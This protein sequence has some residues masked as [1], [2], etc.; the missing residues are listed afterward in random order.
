MLK[1][2]VL[3]L[4][5]V[6]I[7]E[8]QHTGGPAISADSGHADFRILNFQTYRGGAHLNPLKV[9]I[10]LP[11]AS[12]YFI[13]GIKTL[14]PGEFSEK[15]RT[16]PSLCHS[17][18]FHSCGAAW[19]MAWTSLRRNAVPYW[20]FLPPSTA[21]NLSGRLAQCYRRAS[22]IGFSF[23]LPLSEPFPAK[24]VCRLFLIERNELDF[25]IG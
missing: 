14:M 17:S 6:Y 25:I 19:S 3:A 1:I 22:S 23:R 12:E 13:N 10:G 2:C 21:Q 5:T 4:A 7:Y 11:W 18:Q 20:Q 8:Q 15:H 16:N 24:M 9:I